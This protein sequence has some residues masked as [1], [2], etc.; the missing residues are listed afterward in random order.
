MEWGL[1]NGC[2]VI[3]K[4]QEDETYEPD[5]EGYALIR[6]VSRILWSHFE[7]DYEWSPPA[8]AER[9]VP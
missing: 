6:N 8:G 2:C 1:K 4:D 3:T 5:N 7:P 9:F